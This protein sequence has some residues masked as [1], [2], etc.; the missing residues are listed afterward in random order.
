MK[1]RQFNRYVPKLI[2]DELDLITY[3]RKDNLYTIIDLIHRKE[4]YYK[5]D[6]QKK[7]GFTQ[8]SKKQFKQLIPS[9]DNLQQDL[10]F[11]IDKGLILKNKYYVSGKES[12]RYKIP[13]EYLGA[14][15]GLT[16][17]NKNINNRIWKQ[18]L[19]AKRRRVKSLEFA[20]TE[21]FKTFKLDFNGAEKAILDKAMDEIKALCLKVKLTLREREIRDI[22]ECTNDYKKYRAM[23]FCKGKADELNDILHRYMIYSTRLSCIKDGFLFF[24]RNK[25][26]GRLDTNLTSLPSFL[27]P[28][29]ISSEKLMSIDVKNSQP[30]FLY[31]QIKDRPEIDK[32]EFAKYAELVISGTLY[33]FLMEKYN[34][35][36]RWERNRDQI[37][38]MLCKIFYSKTSSFPAYKSFFGSLFPTIMNYINI[39]N[40]VDNSTLANK[41]CSIESNAILDVIMPLL[42]QKGIRPFTIHDSFVCKESEANTI[43]EIFNTKLTE[44]YGIP[45]KLKIEYINELEEEID[46][47]ILDWDKFIEEINA[48]VD[49]D[50]LEKKAK[51]HNQVETP[52]VVQWTKRDYE[53]HELFHLIHKRA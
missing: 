17:T 30:Y 37:K 26:N 42:E 25:T 2:K 28:F 49:K 51:N 20:K 34:A 53:H 1:Q 48:A 15:V 6:L 9:S 8:I 39:T 27:R 44:M 19:A 33:E 24:K 21:Y 18:I 13:S 22:I 3:K 46:D 10:Q 38:E 5:T 43:Q 41:L 16:I 12:Q 47:P 45:P 31:T 35:N 32:T 52:V 36:T 7:Y 50:E 23:I 40:S 11:L 29:I 14:R 4:I